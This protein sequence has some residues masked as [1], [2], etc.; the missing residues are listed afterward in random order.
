MLALADGATQDNATAKL[1]GGHGRLLV[2]ALLFFLVLASVYFCDLSDLTSINHDN[3]TM[4]HASK[5]VG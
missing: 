4:Q 5:W 1:L 2:R 3:S